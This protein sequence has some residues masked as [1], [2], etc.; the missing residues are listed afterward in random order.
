MNIG[1]IAE[2]F[3]RVDAPNEVVAIIEVF[4]ILADRD[5]KFGMPVLSRR[6]GEVTS[7]VV[8]VAVRLAFFPFYLL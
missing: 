4:H 5:A 2:I 1:S 6:N 3:A 7:I 8:P